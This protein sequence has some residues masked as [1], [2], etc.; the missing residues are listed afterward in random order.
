MYKTAIVVFM[1]VIFSF[2]Q[3]AESLIWGQILAL[4]IFMPVEYFFVNKRILKENGFRET[5]LKILPSILISAM[6]LSHDWRWWIVLVILAVFSFYFI[7]IK[8]H[9]FKRSLL[10]E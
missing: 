6:I 3:T 8:G 1:V 5:F 4:L 2:W 9:H 7:Y 10:T